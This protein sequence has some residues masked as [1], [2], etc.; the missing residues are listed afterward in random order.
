MYLA[1]LPKSACN[2]QARIGNTKSFPQ[3]YRNAKALHNHLGLFS[4]HL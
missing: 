4:S 3:T 1:N 2:K